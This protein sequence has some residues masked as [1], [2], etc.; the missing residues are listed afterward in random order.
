MNGER[1]SFD[2]SIIRHT[3]RSRPVVRLPRALSPAFIERTLQAG[4][5]IAGRSAAMQRLIAARAAIKAGS[6]AFVSA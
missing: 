1:F 6:D 3:R 2:G 4:K 5:G